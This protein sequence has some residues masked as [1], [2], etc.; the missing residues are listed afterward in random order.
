MGNASVIA[1]MNGN[2]RELNQS[3]S[4]TTERFFTTDGTVPVYCPLPTAAQLG[5]PNRGAMFRVRAYGTVST[6]ASLTYRTR[7]YYGTS[8]TAADNTLIVDSGAVT[9]ATTTTNWMTEATIC[10]DGNSNIMNGRGWA[11]IANTTSGAATGLFNA[12]TS[13]DPDADATRGFIMSAEYGTG[14][15][16]NTARL[17]GIDIVL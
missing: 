7:L 17:L 13:A 4:S 9:V 5:G 8:I 16:G 6:A 11:S 1:H 10:W 3:A 2:P 14:N 15:V 12:V